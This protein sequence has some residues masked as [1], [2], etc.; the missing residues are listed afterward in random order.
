MITRNVLFC[1]VGAVHDR[2]KVVNNELEVRPSMFLNFTVDH[3]F[4]DGGRTKDLNR[5]V[6][7]I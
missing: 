1:A 3:R 5:I 6:L 4:L 7:Y 2:V